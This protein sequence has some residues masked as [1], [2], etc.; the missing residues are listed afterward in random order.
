[1]ESNTAKAA[2][3]IPADQSQA[4]IQTVHALQQEHSDKLPAFQ[5]IYDNIK[6]L[7]NTAQSHE[8]ERL[9]QEYTEL[10]ARYRVS[11]LF[12]NFKKL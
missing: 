11:V 5:A 9:N 8:S 4:R 1:M 7:T 6:K 12:V 2:D 3:L 10:A